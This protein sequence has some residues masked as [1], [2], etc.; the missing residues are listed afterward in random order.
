[1]AI[2]MPDG[3]YF[4]KGRESLVFPALATGFAQSGQERTLPNV[5]VQAVHVVFGNPRGT[6]FRGDSGFVGRDEGDG[7]ERQTC[8]LKGRFCQP[9]VLTKFDPRP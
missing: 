1:M 4:R 2:S 7:F 6:C 9:R 5:N 8:G 3:K